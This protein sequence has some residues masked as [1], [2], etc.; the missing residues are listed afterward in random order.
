MELLSWLFKSKLSSVPG[1][2]CRWMRITLSD[3]S[4]SAPNLWAGKFERSKCQINTWFFFSPPLQSLNE[5]YDSLGWLMWCNP[6]HDASIFTNTAWVKK[7]KKKKNPHKKQNKTQNDK[8]TSRKTHVVL[9][10]LIKPVPLPIAVEYTECTSAELNVL[11][12]T[13]NNLMVWFK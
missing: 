12:M 3:L 6:L 9:P 1:A 10:V 8:T 4:Q 7:K 2:S 13:L 5:S 11:F